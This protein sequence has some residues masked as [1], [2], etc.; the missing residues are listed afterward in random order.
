MISFYQDFQKYLAR[1][2]M[3]IREKFKNLIFFVSYDIL[4]K[5]TGRYTIATNNSIL[6]SR[7]ENYI[8][9]WQA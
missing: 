5:K 7:Y 8:K 4:T 6:F 2:R 3:V 9:R 1:I